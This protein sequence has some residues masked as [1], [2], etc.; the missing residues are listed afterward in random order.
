MRDVLRWCANAALI[1]AIA[2]A[3]AGCGDEP[4]KDDCEKLLDHMIDVEITAA[5]TDSITPEMKADIAKQKHELRAYLGQ[6]F[7]K[8]CVNELPRSHVDCALN[9]RTKAD[10]A[11]CEKK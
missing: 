7:V 2:A 6:E 9:A 1:A 4:S 5:G 10:V 8:K 3:L 11:A